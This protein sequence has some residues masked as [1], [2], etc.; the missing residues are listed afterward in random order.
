[1]SLAHGEHRLIEKDGPGLSYGVALMAPRRGHRTDQHQRC[2][3]FPVPRTRH[4][5]GTA[6]NK[7]LRNYLM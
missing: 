2:Q 5:A 3:R 1:M 7:L 6:A 4:D